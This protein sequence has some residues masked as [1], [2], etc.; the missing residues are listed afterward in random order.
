MVCQENRDFSCRVVSFVSVFVC[1]C[2]CV[3]VCVCVF[4]RVC[5]CVHFCI[6]GVV[7]SWSWTPNLHHEIK[8]LGCVLAACQNIPSATAWHFSIEVFNVPVWD[9]IH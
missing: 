7:V 9:A 4:V 1:A 6:S 8:L 5:V 2:V 3:R